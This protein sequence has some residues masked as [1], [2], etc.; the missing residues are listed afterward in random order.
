MHEQREVA[1]MRLP[2]SAVIANIYIEYF[3]HRAL[4][5]APQRPRLMEEICG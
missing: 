3:E 4:E 1:A 5:S 2:V